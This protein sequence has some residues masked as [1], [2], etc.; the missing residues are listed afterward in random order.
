MTDYAI[1]AT[2]AKGLIRAVAVRSTK[3]VEEA[4]RRHDTYPVA[5]AALGRVLTATAMLTLDLQEGNSVTVRVNGGGPLGSVTAV[6]EAGGRV[7]GYVQEPHV[8][9]PSRPGH[10]LDVGGAVGRDGLFQVSMDLGLREPYTGSVPL[11]SG[12]IAEDFTRY[13][14]HSQQVPSATALGVLVEADNSVRAAGGYLVQLLPGATDELAGRVE[15]RVQGLPPVSSLL[16]QGATPEGLLSRLLD[17]WQP[18]FYGRQELA[19]SCPCSRPRLEEVLLSLGPEELRGL[20]E[21]QGGAEVKCEFCGEMYYFDRADLAR[22]EKEAS[23]HG[24]VG[25]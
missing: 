14:V 12:E 9:L 6:G 8:H 3:L 4:R 5:T 10:K 24:G 7:R 23:R 22:L 25:N 20:A 11:V 1:R 18:I 15:E 13:L 2:A 17:G 16:D 21:E 19:F